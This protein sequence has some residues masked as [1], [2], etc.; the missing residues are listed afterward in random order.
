M[1]VVK[2]IIIFAAAVSLVLGMVG[3]SM[4]ASEPKDNY[5][6]CL[7]STTG[8]PEASKVRLNLMV[9]FPPKSPM[10]KVTGKMIMSEGKMGPPTVVTYDVTGAYDSM[11]GAMNLKGEG[12]GKDKMRYVTQAKFNLPKDKK[13]GAYEI[14]FKKAGDMDW[15][16]TKGMATVAPCV[17]K[18]ARK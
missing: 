5:K 17:K 18:G 6:L 14:E 9:M 8:K 4:A 11:K 7:E 16:M 3:L 13:K 12:L 10:A 1:K 2:Q 15:M